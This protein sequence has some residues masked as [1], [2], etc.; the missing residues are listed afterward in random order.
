MSK[1]QPF[2]LLTLV[3]AISLTPYS[4]ASEKSAYIGEEHRQI[5]SLSA[6]DIDS[7]RNGKGWGFAKA[8]ELN[9]IPGPS[10]LLQLK[11][12]I[13]LRLDQIIQI[14]A[15]Y[16][17][18]KNQAIP[19][20]L[21]LIELE[22]Q[23]EIAFQTQDINEK[24]LLN[25]LTEISNTKRDLRFIHLSAH[26]ATPFI[27]DKKQI[28]RYNSLRGYDTVTNLSTHTGNSKN[29]NKNHQH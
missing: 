22:N 26:L 19:A 6:S 25:K 2:I 1:R 11:K 9:G 20:G 16:T 27:L 7:L 5:K 24:S 3:T 12:E 17:K 13:P 28:I 29:H 8:A 4:S 21:K 15:L 14:N 18:M 10:H 23:L